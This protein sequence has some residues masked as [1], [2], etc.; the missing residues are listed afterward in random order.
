MHSTQKAE[1]P[2]ILAVD[3][4]PTVLSAVARDLRRE[5]G[6]QYR[7]MRADSGEAAL[8]VARG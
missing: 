4:E 5:Y 7:V 6:Q 2:V 3:D 1:K 8:E